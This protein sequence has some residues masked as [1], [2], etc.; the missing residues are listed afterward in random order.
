MKLSAFSTSPPSQARTY[1]PAIFRADPVVVVITGGSFLV[2]C[3]R[4]P[5]DVPVDHLP[6]AAGPHPYGLMTATFPR[7]YDILCHIN[8]ESSG[9][10]RS[11]RL[12]SILLLLQ[13]RGQLPSSDLASRLEVS[14]RTIMRDVEALSAAGVPVYTVR[15]P[16]GGIALLPG[17]RT[18]VTGLTAEESRSL[19]VLLSGS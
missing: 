15:G 10:M 8:E 3:S 2:H 7:L 13:A 16:Q 14:V 11:D 9:A 12:L 1:S 4:V 18:D 5:G 6:R 19:F 17:Y